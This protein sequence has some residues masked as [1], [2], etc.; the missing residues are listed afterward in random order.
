MNENAGCKVDKP[1]IESLID[2]FNEYLAMNNDALSSEREMIN[3]LYGVP[4]TPQN[5]VLCEAKPQE[6]PSQ[7]QRLS[8]CLDRFYTQ[9]EKANG[10]NGVL[11]RAV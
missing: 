4:E 11:S 1:Q 6:L 8:I 9:I 7:L 2:R 5:P 10:L 3:R